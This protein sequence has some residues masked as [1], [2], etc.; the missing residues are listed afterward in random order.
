MALV[1]KL[2]VA[3]DASAEL[4]HISVLIQRVSYSV[5]MG[6]DPSTYISNNI[7]GDA[8]VAVLETILEN[9]SHV[10]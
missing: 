6:S 8:D 9:L 3:S 5:G 10:I 1:L 4:I 7:P 2:Q